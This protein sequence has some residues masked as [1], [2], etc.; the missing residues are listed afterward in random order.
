MNSRDMRDARE[1]LRNQLEETELDLDNLAP[2]WKLRLTMALRAVVPP[3][4]RNLPLN[5]LKRV[6]DGALLSNELDVLRVALKGLPVLDLYRELSPLDDLLCKRRR[7][8]LANIVSYLGLLSEGGVLEEPTFL[9]R[10]PAMS[11]LQ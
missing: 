3:L 9:L 4:L 2:P 1:L 11:G 10:L 5:A 7:Y 6:M 8:G